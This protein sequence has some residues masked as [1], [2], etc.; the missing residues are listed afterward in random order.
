MLAY[1][2]NLFSGL[3]DG[4]DSASLLAKAKL[5]ANSGN[6]AE[7]LN[8]IIDAVRQCPSDD[9]VLLQAIE[10]FSAQGQLSYAS[11]CYT[12]L[13][14]NRPLSIAEN[15]GCAILLERLGLYEQAVEH[16][17]AAQGSNPEDL[18]YVI[19]TSGAYALAGH[20]RQAALNLLKYRQRFDAISEYWY[21]LAS[22]LRGSGQ[23][24]SATR[25][26]QA[27]VKYSPDDWSHRNQLASLLVDQNRYA[28]A[29]SILI[30]NG[31]AEHSLPC[32]LLSI[33]NYQLGE[34]ADGIE[35]INRAISLAG[36][37]PAY[38]MQ[39]ASLHSAIHD[40]DRAADDFLAVLKSQP[41]HVDA[42]RSAF[43]MLVEAGRYSEAIPIGG[44]LVSEFPDDSDLTQTLQIIIER[45]ASLHTARGFS[46]GKAAE[47]L[48][49]RFGTPPKVDRA[50]DLDTPRGPVSEQ[51]RVI[52]A[53]LLRETRTRFGRSQFGYAWVIFEPLA[54]IGIMIALISIVSHSR[55][56]PIGESFALF[57]FT[58][59]IPYHLFIHTVGHLMHS[60]PENRPLLQLPRVKVIDV[61]FARAILELLTEVCVSIL[62]L[63]G[64]VFF[65]LSIIPINP[66]GVI[67]A[68]L[69]IWL[70][71]FGLGLISAVL[72]RYFSGW[73]RVWGAITSILYFTSGTFY[74]PRM[75]PEWMR[76]ILVWSPTL[77]AIEMVRV[78]YFIEPYPHWLD[79]GYLAKC[80]LVAMVIGLVL[81]RL[82]RN[83]ILEVE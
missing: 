52:M 22:A 23:I 83:K 45:G 69:L 37:Q 28:E 12:K 54:H 2:T 53:L 49:Q 20:P 40:F 5:E 73:A 9:A 30:Y 80:A 79:V 16:Y 38:L 13:G 14:V 68:L 62:L 1:Q 47:M 36:L 55:I 74:I 72:A 19:R 8:L 6:G 60:V 65:G 82:Y 44:A 21:H 67:F 7:T 29:K 64:F 51:W 43:V 56:P 33:I 27:M 24:I 57:Y 25:I 78:N 76:D 71:A 17:F 26:A 46:E 66:I 35:F 18:D 58:G 10:Q 41:L 11:D 77:Q 32:H 61:Y 59:I 75:M 63:C 81:E 48:E 34:Y 4:Q 70:T 50:D 39:R 42:R 3:P 15:L 31:A